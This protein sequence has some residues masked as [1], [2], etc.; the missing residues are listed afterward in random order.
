MCFSGPSFPLKQIQNYRG[1]LCFQ[2]FIDLVWMGQQERMI[3]NSR[4][5]Y[6]RQHSQDIF[7]R[8]HIEI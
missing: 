3:K 7:N 8:V 2:I 6:Y 5:G 1:L 4:P